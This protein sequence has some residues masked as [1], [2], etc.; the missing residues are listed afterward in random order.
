EGDILYL[1]T[2]GY[3]DQFGGE[4]GRKLTRA[5]FREFLLGIAHLDMEQQRESL[6]QFHDEYR[7]SGEQVDDICVMGGRV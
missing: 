5:R 6:L 1:F 3:A 7:G 2:D 4:K